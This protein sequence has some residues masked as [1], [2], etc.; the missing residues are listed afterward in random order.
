MRH[1]GLADLAAVEE[2]AVRMHHTAADLAS[3]GRVRIRRELGRK[4]VFEL[5]LA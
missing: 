2:V 3:A 1:M 5:I 4:L